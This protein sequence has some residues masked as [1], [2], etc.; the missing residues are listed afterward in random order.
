MAFFSLRS[1][2]FVAGAAMALVVAGF[3]ST[4]SA[5]GKGDAQP[6]R[7]RGMPALHAADAK[8]LKHLA[9]ASG[10]ELMSEP[11]GASPGVQWLRV[12]SNANRRGSVL[13]RGPQ[14]HVFSAKVSAGADG[15]H[16]LTSVRVHKPDPNA[17][18]DR[19]AA[20]VLHEA[21]P[22]FA[23]WNTWS[24][25]A[26]LFP[27]EAH[28]VSRLTGGL[29]SRVVKVDNV[30]LDQAAEVPKDLRTFG[31]V[32]R[33]VETSDGLRI[34]TALSPRSKKSFFGVFFDG[35]KVPK[36]AL[37]YGQIDKIEHDGNALVVTYAKK[38]DVV[39]YTVNEK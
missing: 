21:D 28:V 12:P 5:A 23:N 33:V 16:R 10:G 15:V 37:E 26:E 25:S 35:V 38:G 24:L 7:M 39:R 13:L 30:P 2:R 17:L 32:A 27:K 9:G 3:A 14:D 19:K 29:T 8:V 6:V 22:D 4:S 11:N 34:V 1:K 18:E 36:R 31:G 20:G